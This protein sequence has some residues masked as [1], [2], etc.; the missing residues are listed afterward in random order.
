[1]TAAATT[2]TVPAATQSSPTPSSSGTTSGASAVRGA[3]HGKAF[4]EQVQCLAPRRAV[5]REEAA[6][7]TPGTD[8]TG[9]LLGAWQSGTEALIRAAKQ[10]PAAQIAQSLPS[11]G[12]AGQA[13][14]DHYWPSGT[15]WGVTLAASAEGTIAG[16]DVGFPCDI[17]LGG[18]GGVE[19]SLARKGGAIT[20]AA[21]V[22][23]EASGGLVPTIKALE[24]PC[25]VNVS[26]ANKVSVEMDLGAMTWPTNAWTLLAA[27]SLKAAVAELMVSGTSVAGNIQVTTELS[28]NMEE[29]VGVRGDAVAVSATAAAIAGFGLATSYKAPTL[30]KPGE[31][32]VHGDI[33]LFASLEGEAATGS[34]L[35]TVRDFATWLTTI[36]FSDAGDNAARGGV[37]GRLG[38]TV[39]LAPGNAPALPRIDTISLSL[40]G[41]L[42]ATLLGTGIEDG[43]ASLSLVLNPSEIVGLQKDVAAKQGKS[44]AAPAPPGAPAAAAETEAPPKAFA[45]KHQYSGTL[46][47][48]VLAQAL[49]LV[50]GALGVP[51]GAGGDI[52]FAIKC[53]FKSADLQAMALSIG[54]R[55]KAV[56]DALGQHDILG[57]LGAVMKL[58]ADADSELAAFLVSSIDKATFTFKG[59]LEKKID[60]GTTGEGTVSGVAGEA[61]AAAFTTREVEL[62]AAQMGTA[63]L[64]KFLRDLH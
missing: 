46:V 48:G 44:A 18:G 21:E 15:G 34:G 37:I 61:S 43:E 5:Q 50:L 39:T 55:G 36:D 4:D 58:K 9:Y 40:V 60:G 51:P 45:L 32:E 27:G 14:I 17:E 52:E 26:G 3:L 31:L 11:L 12:A 2:T 16:S 56:A 1:M 30:T 62:S 33:G 53:E 7:P 35:E 8:P 23:G 41:Q 13:L 54:A 25:G 42:A 28:A 10:I 20:F 63:A 24:M 64:V 22:T 19:L 59:S 47:P 29:S 38:A 6:A 49:P 57:A